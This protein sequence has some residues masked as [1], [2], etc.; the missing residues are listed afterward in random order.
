MSPK[1]HS[2]LVK[3]S[4]SY[5]HQSFGD[6]L[7]VRALISDFTRSLI[8]GLFERITWFGRTKQDYQNFE[9][10]ARASYSFLEQGNKV[11]HKD[12]AQ[13][14]A[15]V[16]DEIIPASNDSAK[17]GSEASQEPESNPDSRIKKYLEFYK[18]MYERLLPIICST[19][20]Y[21]FGIS[22]NSKEKAFIPMDDGKVSL[23]AI[24]KMEKL[25]HYPE[26]RLAIGINS[27]IRNAYA[28]E[29]YK[30][31][32]GARVELWD[33]NPNTR[34]LTWGPE[35]WTLQQLITLCDELWVNSL[36]ITC[37]LV[38]YD[39]NNRQIVAE[40]GWVSPAKPPPLR[41]G[42]LKNTIDSIV[43]KLGF[44]LK[45]IKV[46][47][48]FISLTLSTKSKGINQESKLMLGY[49]NHVR[50]FKI[51]MWYEEKRIIDQLV[52]F[53]HRIIPY[54]EPDIKISIQVLSSNGEPLGALITDLPTIIN[55]NLV[56]IKPEIVEGIRHIFKRDTLQDC[57]TFVEKEGAPKFVGISPSPP[58]K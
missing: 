24:D 54:V 25:L 47:P 32:D 50:L 28:H 58:K 12:I 9:R 37:A 2:P 22:K 51:P 6:L 13:Q 1:E 17:A 30:I 52:I 23:K 44:Y 40:R 10:T 15:L 34:K 27:H 53:L 19:I 45:D 48:N 26:N 55:L 36:G 4:L 35:I 39:V 42:E 11:K 20:I 7:S 16:I 21:A 18:V 5:F 29:N 43:D 38:L 31:L 8:E 14:F 56:S 3:L 49:E 33:I 57:V 41:E 46:S